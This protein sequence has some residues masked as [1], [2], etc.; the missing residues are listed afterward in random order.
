MSESTLFEVPQNSPR[1]PLT[2]IRERL[3]LV[4]ETQMSNAELLACAM[5]LD[6]A[7]AMATYSVA[8]DLR[9]LARLS[10]PEMVA[11][12]VTPARAVAFRAGIELGRRLTAPSL[13]DRPA[14]RMPEDVYHL[15]RPTLAHLERERLSV[16]LLNTKHEVLAVRDVYQ[17]TVCAASV[18]VAEILEPAIRENCP[19]IILAHNHPSGDPTPSPEDTGVTR[20]VRVSAELMDIELLDHVVIGARGFVSMKERGLG[21]SA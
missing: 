8:G 11:A 20:R 12:G 3:H 17:G 15:L 19:N 14:I 13:S 10:V 16:L 1:A 5:S 2:E 18:R 4:G 21:F 9:A 7:Q 6:P